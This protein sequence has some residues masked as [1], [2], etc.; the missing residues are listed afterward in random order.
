MISEQTVEH[1]C[2]VGGIGMTGEERSQCYCECEVADCG[3]ITQEYLRVDGRL[4]CVEC[5][6]KVWN[7]ERKVLK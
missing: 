7:D 5:A 3:K 6:A 1:V 4:Y 2:I